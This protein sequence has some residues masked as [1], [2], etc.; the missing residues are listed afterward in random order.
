MGYETWISSTYLSGLAG[1]LKVSVTLASILLASTWIGSIGQLVGA[2][3]FERVGS[4]KKYTLFVAGAARSLWAVPLLVALVF[5]W[6]AHRAGQTFPRDTWIL[7]LAAVS[8]SS[9]LL[10]TSSVASWNSWVR[11]LVPADFRG[12]FFGGRQRYVMIAM[13]SANLIASFWVDWRPHGYYA[14]YVIL[15]VLALLCATV[16]T[17]LLTKIPE[18]AAIPRIEKQTFFELIREPFRNRR[19]RN[20]LIFG[21]L[22]NGAVQLA[23]PFFPYYFTKELK[24][25]MASVAIWTMLASAGSVLASGFWGRKIDRGAAAKI[26]FYCG[27]LVS[28]SPLPYVINSGKWIS[29]IGG[30]E[31][32][33]NGLYSSGYLLAMTAMLFEACPEGRN[34]IYF[35]VAI[36]ANGICGALANFVAARIAVWLIPLGGFRALFAIASVCRLIAVNVGYRLV[37]SRD[38]SN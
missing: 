5:A 35:S 9:A 11:S 24:I 6:L 17:F 27:L 4:P 1:E 19:F 23:G 3:A 30:A 29:M 16:S 12:R 18:P 21:A 32:F 31:Y 36:A 26:A 10:A 8:C 33:S 20:V 7:I 14:G 28:C 13:V 37:K 25:P 15:A 34:A 2:W 22:M 38:S